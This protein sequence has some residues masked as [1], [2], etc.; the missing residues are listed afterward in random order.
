[1]TAGMP[2]DPGFDVVILG[3]GPAGVPAALAAVEA[4]ARVIV[5]DASDAPGGQ[6]HR[7]PADGLDA[8]RPGALH[9]GWR[10]AASG[11]AALA[12]HPRVEQLPA[13]RVWL[14]E[15]RDDHVLVHTTGAVRATIRGRTLVLATGATERV[16]PFPGWDLPGVMTVGAA[17]ALV[18]GQGIRPGHRV[19]LA[20]TGPLLLAAASTLLAVGTRVA[21]VVDANGPA[22]WA[23]AAGAGLRTPGKVVEAG[24]YLADLVRHGVPYRPSRAVIRVAGADHV[25][26]ATVARVDADWRVVDGTQED[27]AVDA[28]CVSYGFTANVGVA[29]GLGCAL[30]ADLAV[31]TDPAQRTSVD[32][33]FAA[34]EVTGVAGASVAA[35]EGEV[36][37]AAAAD[38]A[39]LA[40]DRAHVRRRVRR[41]DRHRRAAQAV[42]AGAPVRDG[43]ATWLDD[44]TIVCRCEEVAYGTVRHAVTELGARDVR[45]V[46]MTT[47]CGMGL[48]QAAMCGPSVVDLVSQLTAGRPADAAGLA[49]RS[50]ADAVPLGEL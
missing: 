34:G 23:A 13:T 31:R 36:A 9:H 41:R 46:K 43:W 4:G 14:V 48:C 7:Q 45:S 29:A 44:D 20:G 11:F 16:L 6:Y 18:K 33:V 42:A 19:L 15:Q 37:G 5:I 40:I 8:D 50:I 22:T 35:L 3:A 28:V 27:H 30:T 17:Q 24:G 2:P 12:D 25:E 39:G 47:R 49:H 1:M 21:A 32:R 26:R 38:R 10:S